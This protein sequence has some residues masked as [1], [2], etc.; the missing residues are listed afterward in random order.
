MQL[1]STEQFQFQGQ[2][3]KSVIITNFL[4]VVHFA[5][6]LPDLLHDFLD[7]RSLFIIDLVHILI[8]LVFPPELGYYI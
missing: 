5:L 1:V 7:V 8:A 6:N 2:L 4:G 3:F